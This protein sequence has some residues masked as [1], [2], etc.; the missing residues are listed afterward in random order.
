[1]VGD[2]GAVT[3]RLWQLPG[4]GICHGSSVMAYIKNT[5]FLVPRYTGP[6]TQ[7]IVYGPNARLIVLRGPGYLVLNEQG[8]V[9]AFCVEMAGS[10]LS[11]AGR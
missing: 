2:G 4:Y 10:F 9:M 1:M 7:P 6:R 5:G 3:R 11:S 8:T